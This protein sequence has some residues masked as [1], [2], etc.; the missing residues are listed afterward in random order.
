MRPDYFLGRPLLA[1][2]A[3]VTGSWPVWGLSQSADTVCC[4][5]QDEHLGA[6]VQHPVGARVDRSQWG[7]GA[8]SPHVHVGGLLQLLGDGDVG[9][10]DSCIGTWLA[11]RGRIHR[12]QLVGEQL[13]WRLHHIL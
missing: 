7:D 10:C 3:G 1:G 11:R 12:Y 2:A 5:L 9:G 13:S 6:R 8:T 4:V